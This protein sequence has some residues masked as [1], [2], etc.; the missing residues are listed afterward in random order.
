MRRIAIAAFVT[1]IAFSATAGLAQAQ[2]LNTYACQVDNSSGG[3]PLDGFITIDIFIDFEGQY[4]GAQML[5]DLGAGDIYQDG[6]GN[7]FPPNPAFLGVFP[8]LAF[9]T[10]VAMGSAVDDGNNPNLN[11]GAVDLG[12]APG[13]IISDSMLNAAWGPGGGVLIEDQVGFLVAR[14]TLANTVNGSL[15]FFGSS[16]SGAF[17]PLEIP[18]INGAMGLE[19]CIPE[20]STLPLLLLGLSA[21]GI[22]RRR[23]GK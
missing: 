7:D 16:G 19:A 9:D 20:P 5:L 10:F 22:R 13:A 18:I 4:N 17:T 15:L 3:A 1:V 21:I 2:V 23:F 12:G 8:S 6:V 11:G 14:V